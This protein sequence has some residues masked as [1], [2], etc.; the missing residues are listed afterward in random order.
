MNK[1]QFISILRE[2]LN[3]RFSPTLKV[4][5]KAQEDRIIVEFW[6]NNKELASYIIRDVKYNKQC[7]LCLL[8]QIETLGTYGSERM[9]NNDKTMTEE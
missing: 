7:L 1:H 4:E 6:R 2:E 8:Q 5:V 9:K 3:K